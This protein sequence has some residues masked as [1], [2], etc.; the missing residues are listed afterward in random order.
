MI[1][2]M[3]DLPSGTV[4]FIFT[5][6]EGSTALLESLGDEYADVLAEHRR[7]LRAAF[8]KRGGVEVDTQGDAFFYAF[9][10]AGDAVEAASE[11]QD[12]LAEGPVRV[13]IGVH[14]GEP[15]VAAEGYVGIDVHRAA[16]IA[17]AANGGQVVI[18]QTTRDLVDSDAGLRDLGVHRL[19]DLTA[20]ERLY[21]LGDDEFPPLRTLDATNLPVTSST[22]LGREEE[23]EQLMKLLTDGTR[24]VT[25]TGPGG[26]GKTRLALQVAAELVG[27]FSDGVFWV[28]LAGV[29]D[30]ELV[31][32]EIARTL[33]ARDD[34]LGYLRGK[35]LLLLVDNFE[36]LLAAAPDLASLLAAAD[37]LRVIATSRA[38][39][40]I[41]GER[42]YPLDPLPPKDAVTLFLE[43]ARAVGKDFA[44]SPTI[45][46]ICRNLDGLPLAI[47]LAAART[48]LL[49]PEAL[50]ERLDRALSVLTGGARD[51]PERQRT[52]RATI[53]WSHDLLQQ[54]SKR[55]FA[56]LSVFL[57]SFPLEAAEE[58]CDADLDGIA[59]LV[60]LSL[61]KPIAEDRFLMLETIREYAAEKLEASGEGDELRRRHANA[62]RSLAAECYARRVD[63]EAESSERLESDHDD[64]RA[65]LEWLAAHDPDAELELAGAL[66]WFWLSHSHLSEGR[67]R[68]TDALDRSRGEGSVRAAALT[69]VVALAGWQGDADRGPAWLNEGIALWRDLG[70]V[71]EL[72]YALETLGWVL[73]AVGDNLPGLAVFEESL[74]LRRASGDALGEMRSLGGVCQMLVAES[75]VDRAEPLSRQLLE[76]ARDRGDPRSEHFAHHFLGDCALIRGDC[77]EAEDLY[78]AS[79]RAALPLGD[80]LETSFEV[81]GVGMSAAGK[82]D[83]ARGLRL[84][85]AGYALWE[86]IGATASVP[87]W[88]ALMESYISA[89]RE[90]LGSEGDA[91]W[92]EGHAMP[93]EDAVTL[94]LGSG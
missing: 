51:A 43:R 46:T 5:D 6:I 94:A 19:K 87:F 16:R 83:W 66:G 36:H 47:E 7:I 41:S 29:A 44:P 84:V 31:L 50:L 56:R 65:A 71:A 9:T 91:V 37:G 3:R 4:T 61:L 59:A 77:V 10:R 45:E 58:V 34:L 49:S 75:E 63:A 73:F 68:L 89:A 21:Q 85:S 35:G 54:E 14:T 48:K 53:E 72:A 8:T 30:P 69:A 86:S 82:G 92:A 42:E 1:R 24:L 81:Q 57:G 90:K 27:T 67:R 55:L 33:P 40:R 79:L 38:P 80:L 2:A 12:G 78:R 25:V 20:P 15:L 74:E 23:L 39:L 70:D 64:L 11:G 13:R 60:D 32:P 93:F 26:T 76:L 88:N 62:F 18:S 17:A 28:P 52:L 22:L